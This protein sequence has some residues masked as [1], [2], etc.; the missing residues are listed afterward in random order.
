ME[1]ECLAIVKSCQSLRE[2]LIGREFSR[3]TD[4]FPLQWLNKMKDQNIRLLRWSLI[5]QEFRFSILHITGKT[6]VLTDMLSRK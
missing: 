1:K 5:L 4:H 3:E 6:N 2:Y